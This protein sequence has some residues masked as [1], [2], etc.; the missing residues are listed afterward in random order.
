MQAILGIAFLMAA[1]WAL[2][3]SRREI[4]WRT[5]AIGLTIQFAL[6][7]LL[8]RVPAVSQ[9]LLLLNEV[10]YAVETATAAGS[11]FV[12]GFLGGGD[13]PFD[14]TDPSGMYIFAFRVLPQIIV[15]SVLVAIFWYWRVAARGGHLQHRRR[16]GPGNPHIGEKVYKKCVG[17]LSR[18]RSCISQAIAIW[19]WLPQGLAPTGAGSHRGWLPQGMASTRL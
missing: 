11:S 17:A 12:F 15:F 13:A 1:A 9:G 2:S 4:R 10:V 18:A 16:G 7:L 19:R 8:L 6:A 5:V 3:E 14:V